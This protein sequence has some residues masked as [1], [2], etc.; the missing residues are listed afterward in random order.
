MRIGRLGGALC[1]LLTVVQFGTPS[2]ADGAS[3][4][5]TCVQESDNAVARVAA[6]SRLIQ[7]AGS[8]STRLGLLYDSRG[9]GFAKLNH[10]ENAISDF[11]MAI[12]LQPSDAVAYY[13]RGYTFMALRKYEDAISD[14]T[15]AIQMDPDDEMAIGMR[16]NAFRMQGQYDRAIDDYNA[17]IRLAPLD[18]VAFQNRAVTY[19]RKGE[20]GKAISDLDRAIQLKSNFTNALNAR[21]WAR[22]ARGTDLDGALADCDAA[23]RIDPSF[24]DA[25]ESRGLVMLRMERFADAVK[26]FNDV[27]AHD[28]THP[29]SLY[30]R[31]IAKLRLKDQTGGQADIKAAV[32]AE[33]GIASEF[34]SFGVSP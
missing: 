16:G 21:C 29:E 33:P 3:D 28:Q 13:N 15:V 12:K 25:I 27:L 5:Q 32:A 26:A 14:F 9:V 23:L 7:A 31:G 10:N 30:G 19:I 4:Y 17:A 1:L 20:Y 2:F 11:S 8:G 22:A 24:I 6:C 34:A 18:G